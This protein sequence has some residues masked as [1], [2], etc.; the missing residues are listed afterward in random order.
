ME[1][2]KCSTKLPIA[3]VILKGIG[4]LRCPGCN[5]HLRVSGIDKAEMILIVLCCLTFFFVSWM[6]VVLGLMFMFGAFV[7]LVNM[8]AKVALVD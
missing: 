3:K 2:P 7:I 8:L 1:C 6:A 5:S 4:E